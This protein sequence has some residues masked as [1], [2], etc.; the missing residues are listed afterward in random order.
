M[1]CVVFFKGD[2]VIHQ[3]DPRVRIIFVVIFSFLIALSFNI[4]VLIIG[5]VISFILCFIAQLPLRPILKR[6]L[7]L[8]LFLALLWITL[9]LTRSG[10]VIFRIGPVGYYQG[11]VIRAFTIMLKSNAIVLSITALLNTIEI[12]SL[13]HAL[14]H[15]RIPEQLIYLLLFM[16]LMKKMKLM[17]MFPEPIL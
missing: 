9:P 6:M 13:G 11:G 1:S 7:H 10:D 4:P 14:S 17:W 2:S 5:L 15:M 8:N 3:L 12:I 16:Q